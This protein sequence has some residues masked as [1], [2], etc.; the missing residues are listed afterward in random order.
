MDTR[1]GFITTEPQRELSPLIFYSFIYLL[2][3]YLWRLVLCWAYYMPFIGLPSIPAGPHLIIVPIVQ[4]EQV[5]P[6]TLD[7]K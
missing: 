6:L 7:N 5:G 3:K 2:N 1:F 4:R